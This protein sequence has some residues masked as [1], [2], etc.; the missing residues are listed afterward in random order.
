MTKGL[1]LEGIVARIKYIFENRLQ[2]GR[3]KT[4]DPTFRWFRVANRPARALDRLGPYRFSPKGEVP[5]F[6][7]NQQLVLS[8]VPMFNSKLWEADGTINLDLFSW[9]FDGPVGEIILLEFDMYHHHLR[10]INGKDNFGWLRSMI[11]SLGQQVMRQDPM[12]YMLYAAL[13]PDKQWRLV[14]YPYYA[15]YAVKGDKTYFR[16]ID[17]NIPELLAS[18]RG[19]NMIQGSVSLNNKD[20]TNYTVLIP[21]I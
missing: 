3:L 5:P 1:G 10:K 4:E 12:Y 20:K 13:R 8:S 6:M 15:K 7:F 2:I 9:W 14:T 11:Y 19:S 16:H 18:R 17:V 21:R